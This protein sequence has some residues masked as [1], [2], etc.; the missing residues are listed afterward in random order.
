MERHQK[1]DGVWQVG[2]DELAFGDSPLR[3]PIPEA[4]HPLVKLCVGE[5]LLPLVLVDED[6]ERLV[7]VLAHLALQ[8]LPDVHVPTD[9]RRVLGIQDVHRPPSV[10][11][12]ELPHFRG[13]Q[14]TFGEGMHD[15]G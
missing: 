2:E 4:I 7:C 8:Q 11:R 10:P 14:R 1:T 5:D 12:L 13:R 15:S 6:D 3:E 9:D